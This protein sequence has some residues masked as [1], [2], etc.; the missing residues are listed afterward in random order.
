MIR[1]PISV[2][3]A[4]RRSRVL[5][6]LAVLV[7]LAAAC[8]PGDDGDGQQPP[9]DLVVNLGGEVSVLEDLDARPRVVGPRPS[10]AEDADAYRLASPRQLSSGEIVG[11]RDGGVVAIEPREP[12]RAVL[13]G[14]AGAWFPSSDGE[15]LWAVNEQA[16]D[17]GC[18]GQELP[19]SVS[20]RF[21]V[22]KYET[23]GRP[24]RTT[25]TLPCGMR[26]IADT[27]RGLLAERTTGDAGSTGAGVRAVTDVVILNSRADAATETIATGAAVVAASGNHVIWRDDAC[28]TDGCTHV[29]DLDRR[30]S[31]RTPSCES[32]D[33]VGV[34]TLDPGG[35]FYVSDLRT[36]RLA[37]LDLERGTCREPDEPAAP[38]AGDLERT[39]AA[40]WSGQSLMLLDQRSGKLTVVDAAD[41]KVDQRAEPLPVVNQAQIWGTA[42]K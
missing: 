3:A 6:G 10:G 36:D 18:T 42:G 7:T 2:T 35:R 31:V 13:L 27:P 4:A 12:G 20:V 11:I 40:A 41:G 19:Q 17:T 32:G 38:D 30:K 1:K 33:P 39:F 24:S 34:G 26:P 37:I 9:R 15:R 21:T 28:R 8:G 5:V 22:S 16:A 29:Y 25:L 23:S 14:E